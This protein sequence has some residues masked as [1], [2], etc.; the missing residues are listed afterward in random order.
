MQPTAV[1]NAA[2]EAPEDSGRYRLAR[3]RDHWYVAVRSSKLGKRPVA[4]TIFD[5]PL[6]LFRNASGTAAALLDRCAH[7]NVPL[8]MGRVN[9]ER[10]ACRY[11]GWEYDAEGVCRFIP[12]LCGP[13]EARSRRVTAFPVVEQQGFVWVWM[14]P[15][16]EPS[17]RPHHFEHV[18]DTSYRSFVVDYRVNATLHATFENML[19]VPH[20]AFLHRGLFRGGERNRITAVVR[21]S[22]GG[23][24]AQYVGEPRPTGL[25]A[26]ILGLGEGA[27]DELVH[28]DR[29]LLP[30][31][32]QVEYRLGNS[33]FVAT[34]ALTPES[35]F[36]TRF[37]ALLTYRLPLPGF[38]LRA[39]FEPV[40]RRILGQDAH[41]LARQTD[42]VRRF[43]G[44][45]YASTSVDVLGPE[46]WRLLKRAADGEPPDA[47][48]GASEHRVDLLV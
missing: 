38:L 10:L 16:S 22:A 30:S 47:S 6:V 33:H 25:A 23:V 39:L 2:R 1:T 5:L 26:R 24:E 31:I 37:S 44:E 41:V 8:S 18:D 36:V 35:D 9:G 19:D 4:T 20:T 46:I 15:E 12:A 21:R 7:R 40:A 11:H 42:T 28:F 17:C 43:G 34:S 3:L 27:D 13:Q 32:S 14:N 29:F 48:V 45:R